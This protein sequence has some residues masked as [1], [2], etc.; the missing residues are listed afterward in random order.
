MKVIFTKRFWCSPISSL[1]AKEKG[2]V[3]LIILILILI[4]VLVIAKAV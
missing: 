2:Y 1:S 3:M 4:T